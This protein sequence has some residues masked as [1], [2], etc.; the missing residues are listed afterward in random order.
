M[1]DDTYQLNNLD[2]SL[3]AVI[4]T[5]TTKKTTATQNILMLVGLIKSKWKSFFI[6]M[7]LLQ[8]HFITLN[9]F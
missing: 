7:F 6:K 9:P 5:S 4:N 8:S 1:D 2:K 3:S